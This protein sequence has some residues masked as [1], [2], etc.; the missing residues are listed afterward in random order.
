[1]GKRDTAMGEIR[2]FD[3]QTV[4]RIVESCQG[5]H[6]TWFSLL[7]TIRCFREFPR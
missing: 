2:W 4:I 3:R 1:M 5:N 6:E 7:V